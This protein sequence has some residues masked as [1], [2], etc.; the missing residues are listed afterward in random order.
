MMLTTLA[1]LGLAAYA[2]HILEEH[3]FDWRNWARGVMGLPVEW[4]DFYVTNAVVIVLGI[5]QAELAAALPLAP[6][7]FAM[8]MLINAVV[9]HILPFIRARGRFS[10]GLITAVVLFIPLGIAVIYTALPAVG[11]GTLVAAFAVAAVIMAYPVVMLNAK[12]KPF[13]RQT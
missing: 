6:L 13:F 8:L 10:P 2:A 4:T 3:T 12:S 7:S 9:F 11:W 5:V 1:W